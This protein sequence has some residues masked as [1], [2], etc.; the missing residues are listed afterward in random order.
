MI[1][2][3]FR[4]FT[5]RGIPV[6][7]SLVGIIFMAA[8]ILPLGGIGIS[9]SAVVL[10]ATLLVGLV[11]SILVHEL[12]HAFVG[13]AMGATVVSIQLDLLGGA[14]FFAHRPPSYFKDVVISLAGP[15]SNF[16]LWKGFELL[17]QSMTSSSSGAAGVNGL[18]GV[19]SQLGIALYFLA[20]LNLFLG[21]FNA[22]P[23]YPLD[24]GQAIYAIVNWITL[25][26]KFAAG[27]VLVTS[28]LVVF[29]IF[30]DRGSRLGLVSGGIGLGGGIFSLV[31]ATWIVISSIQLY[32]RA[33]SIRVFRPTPRQ[34]AERQQQEAT[35]R[36]KTHK[37]YQD[38]EQGRAY[39]L[40]R[41]YSQAIA[42]FN[43]ALEL[44]PKELNYLDYRAYTYSQMGDY[45][46]ALADYSQLSEKA[47]KRVDYYTA[48]GEIYL[49]L[50][51]LELAR[52]EVEKALSLNSTNGPALQLKEEL[53][54]VQA[55]G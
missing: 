13:R 14:C 7:M 46:S 43:R 29:E 36:A 47:P 18:G 44:E 10:S 3:T 11:L 8:F 9:G 33:T 39:L 15:A 49:K 2:P 45:P 40:N 22:L 25:R 16:V 21:V 50:G 23:A 35:R 37:G 34:E 5:I 1:G 30:F 52:Q 28:C 27:V 54:R 12:A 17:S 55:S 19:S 42:S 6:Q 51:Q 24:G 4:L 20:N 26:D 48:R 31:I 41:D 53:S 38:F 32:N